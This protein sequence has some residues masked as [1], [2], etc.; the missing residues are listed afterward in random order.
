M[1]R[2]GRDLVYS[3]VGEQVLLPV[4]VHLE[5][6]PAA[7]AVRLAAGVTDIGVGGSRG[8]HHLLDGLAHLFLA[9]AV[10]EVSSRT[11]PST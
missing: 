7:G 6:H 3:D 1:C 11:A 8:Q 4:D 5:V 9:A 10:P 2:P